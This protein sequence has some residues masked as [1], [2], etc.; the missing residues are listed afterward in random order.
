[1]FCMNC[2]TQLESAIS[3]CPYCME[4]LQE[5]FVNIKCAN[6]KKLVQL[7]PDINPKIHVMDTQHPLK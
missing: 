5:T 2:G 7:C 3:V 1:M 6:R 4:S